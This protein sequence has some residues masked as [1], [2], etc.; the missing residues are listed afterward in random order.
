MK[1]SEGAWLQ[2]VQPFTREGPTLLIAIDILK[3]PGMNQAFIVS[4]V[5][6]NLMAYAAIP[7]A[8]RRPVGTPLSWGEAM[9]A[10]TYAF[11]TMFISFG[12]VPHQW[13]THADRDLK[14]GT[15]RYVFGPFDIFKAQAQGGHFPMTIPYQAIRDIVVVV[16]HAYYFG[17]VIYLWH[18]WQ[19]R[20]E[21]KPAAIETSTYGRPLVKPGSA[22][23]A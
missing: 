18:V 19:K 9:L 16:I 1:G 22:G 11:I 6:S 10:G 21:K 7:Y 13:I 4:F 8:K 17:L 23:S 12:I 14:W 20:G 15:T 2:F 3:W 5:V